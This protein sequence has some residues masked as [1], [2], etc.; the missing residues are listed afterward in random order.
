MTLCSYRRT[1]PKGG[2]IREFYLSAII[3]TFCSTPFKASSAR[4]PPV[5]ATQ[6]ITS[7]NLGLCRFCYLGPIMAAID[8][9]EGSNIEYKRNPAPDGHR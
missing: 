8:Y 3:V 7:N 5:Q 6:T 2:Y 9:L 1:G 4:T